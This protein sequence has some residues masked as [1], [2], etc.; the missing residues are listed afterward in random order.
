MGGCLA[1]FFFL[2]ALLCLGVAWAVDPWKGIAAVPCLLL[3][4]FFLMPRRFLLF[5]PIRRFLTWFFPAAQEFSSNFQREH[6][7]CA[8]CWEP[9]VLPEAE[10]ELDGRPVHWKC[11][12][13]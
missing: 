8:I 3:G 11:L 4:L 10:T 6:C 5:G 12:R 1:L 9:I 7:T 13:K 2:M